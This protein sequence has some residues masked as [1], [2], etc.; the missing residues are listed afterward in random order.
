[1]CVKQAK[2]DTDVFI[3]QTAFKNTLHKLIK[4]L[5]FRSIEI[6]VIL[7]AQ[8]SPNLKF[9]IPQV[10]KGSV[11]H[12]IYSSTSLNGRYK[13]HILFLHVFFFL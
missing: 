7:T 12:K 11:E 3:L 2:D 5:L 10:R 13:D 1:M 4:M 6:I 8:T 9:F